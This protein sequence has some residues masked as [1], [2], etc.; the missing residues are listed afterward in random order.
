MPA[1]PTPAAMRA[2][3]DAPSFA[4][5][6]AMIRGGS[7]AP[8]LSMFWVPLVSAAL[9]VLVGA[10]GTWMRQPWLFAALAPTIFMIAATPGHETTSF[11]AIVV[12]HIAAIGCA[13]VAL[14]LLDATT[15]QS[16]LAT[17]VVPMPQIGRAHV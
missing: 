14:L 8:V 2:G 17:R 9:I 3:V 15:S 13:Y 6:T 1:Y 4:K 12:G 11:R 7:I 10:I 5:L 16:M